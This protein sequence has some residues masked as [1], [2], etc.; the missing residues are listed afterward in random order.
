MG[1]SVAQ[2]DATYGHLGP[3]SEELIRGLFDAGDSGR[4]GH[5]WAS[6]PEG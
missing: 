1:T 3:D 4:L 2:I 6:A 5:L